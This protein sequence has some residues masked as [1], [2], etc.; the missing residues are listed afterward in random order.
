MQRIKYR[1][2]LDMLEVASQTTI[3]AK[4]G[5]TACSLVM[6]LTE[7]GKIYH[8]TDGCSAVFSGKKADG[9]YLFN[10]ETCRIE[11]NTI[12]YDFTEQTVAIEGIVEC[13]VI[14]YKDDEQLTTPRFNILVGATVYNGEEIVSTPEADALKE[15]I[16]ES[17]S[18]VNNI[19]EESENV[20]EEVGEVHRNSNQYF[21]NAIKGTASGVGLR[22]TDISPLQHN[23]NAKLSSNIFILKE[24]RGWLRSDTFVVNDG[25]AVYFKN[26]KQCSLTTTDVMWGG[27]SVAILTSDKKI[28]KIE[29]STTDMGYPKYNC[30][31]SGSSLYVTG[32]FINENTKQPVELIDKIFNVSSGATIVGVSTYSDET[33]NYYTITADV[34]VYR[35]NKNLLSYPYNGTKAAR[36]MTITD[37]GDGS[38]TFNGT[39]NDT[40]GNGSVFYFRYNEPITL[41]T[42]HYVGTV[43]DDKGVE[44]KDLTIIGAIIGGNSPSFTSEATNFKKPTTLDHIY[45]RTPAGFSCT[46]LTVY[47][48]I[49]L[50]GETGYE[51]PI[52]TTAYTPNADGT[53]TVPS[54]YPITRLCTN[55]EDVTIDAEYN[56]DIKK[57]IDNKFAALQALVLEV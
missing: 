51:P 7:N 54:A 9:N 24:G 18:R 1:I 12:I 41:P 14:L 53:L 25:Q 49:A 57:Y 56:V 10:G 13:E 36:G 33:G 16:E 28:H 44:L 3:K 37:N 11:D 43:F 52:K 42:G 17:E 50:N 34:E 5:D 47:P 6:T 19:V 4:K 48:M 22:V 2:S 55:T 15:F 31:I 46:N 20:I 32:E 38:L 8:I 27:Y 30:R 39:N 40:N 26:V 45:I 23:I 29:L 35:S 21:S